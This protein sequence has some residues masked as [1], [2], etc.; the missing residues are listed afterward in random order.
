MRTINILLL[1]LLLSNIAQGQNTNKFDQVETYK[2][3]DQRS[4]TISFLYPKNWSA[5]TDWPVLVFYFGGGWAK[6]SVNQFLPHARYFAK[7]GMVCALVDYRVR[8]KDGTDPFT[9]L[10]DAKSAMRYIKSNMQKHHID[11]SRV[12]ASGGSAGGHLAA[13]CQLVK[14]Y[15]DPQ[16]DLSIST[17]VSA[18]VL[19]NPVLDNGPDGYGYNRIGKQYTSFSPFFQDKKGMADV[20][21]LQG[22]ADKLIPVKTMETFCESVREAGSYCNLVLYAEAKHGFFNRGYKDGLYY[23]QTLQEMENF[24][25][26]RNFIGRKN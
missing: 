5:R 26:A 14:G 21:I 10:M 18:L 9:S 6:G 15:D 8:S 22:T 1:W 3:T 2:T 24:L 19:F 12:V 4:L 7:K 20:L 17:K 23:R 11:S 13:A 25:R 16:D